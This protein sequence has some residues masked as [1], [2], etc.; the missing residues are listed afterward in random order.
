MVIGVQDLEAADRLR[1]IL[2]FI[3]VPKEIPS[4]LSELLKFA[5]TLK[6]KPTPDGPR[7]VTELRNR[8]LEAIHEPPPLR[9]ARACGGERKGAETRTAAKPFS[10]VN[11]CG[12]FSTRTNR[13]PG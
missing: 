9:R 6:T 3:G 8:E 1:V 4:S 2:S 5:Q 13:R 10:G 7:I 12:L 11:S